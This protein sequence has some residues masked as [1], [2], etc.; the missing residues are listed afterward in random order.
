MSIKTARSGTTGYLTTTA[1]APKT[2]PNGDWTVGVAVLFDGPMSGYGAQA[3]YLFSTG[4]Y[5]AAGSFN[6]VFEPADSGS[7][8]SLFHLFLDNVGAAV[9]TS[10]IV[11]VAGKAYYFVFQR[12]GTTVSV[13]QCPILTTAPTDGSSVVASTSNNG[14]L[15]NSLSGPLN[16]VIGAR[17]DLADRYFGQ[18]YAR[19]FRLD[20]VTL[21][22]LE[23]AKLAYGMEITELGKTPSLYIR[24]NDAT[25]FTDQSTNAY[26][27]TKSGT[28]AN[29]SSM[30]FGYVSGATPAAPVITGSPSINNGA[31][32]GSASTY[33]PASV[34]GN[35]TPTR[36]L[37]WK[38]DGVAVSGATGTTYAPVAGDSGKTLTITQTEANTQ[39]STS[40]TSAGVVVATATA[41][42]DVA[43]LTAERIYQRVGTTSTVAMSGSYTSTTPTSIEYQLYAEDGVTILVPWTTIS[44][45]TIASGTWSGSPAV[46]QGGM[47][48]L[49][50]RSKNGADVLATSSIKT[51]LF[52]VGDLIA[53]IGSSSPAKWFSSDSGSGF[54]AAANVRRHISGSWSTMGTAG[55]AI[56]MAN[57]FA[58]NAG[59]PVGLLGYGVP[60][61][62]LAPGNSSYVDWLTQ[63]SAPWSN[64]AS[65][66]TAV[67]GKLKAC[68]ISVG[69]NDAAVSIVGSRASHL[70]NLRTFAGNI[71]TLCAQSSLPLLLSGFNRRNPV[72]TAQADFVRMAENDF[73]DDLNCYHN[74]A[75]DYELNSDL[76]HLSAT[77]FTQ[78]G[79]RMR[80]VLGE[81]LYSSTYHRGPKIVGMVYSG[82]TITVSLQHRNGTDFT[83]ST[84]INGFTIT[85][86]DSSG[87]APT[88]NSVARLSSTQILITCNRSLV[89]P[90][91][92]YLSGGAPV[93]A[94]TSAPTN[95]AFDNGTVALPV[96][97]ETDM[98]V[99]ASDSAAPTMVG[100]IV[101]S[102]V[103]TT[104]FTLTWQAATDAVGVTGYKVSVD[105]GSTY[106]DV[107]NVLTYTANGLAQNTLYNTR[108]YAYD[109]A[110]NTATPLS[111]A[112]TTATA[113]D[114]TAPVMVA[115]LASSNI[116]TSAFTLSWSAA[117]DNVAVTGY[118][119][120]ID[121]GATYVSAGNVLTVTKTG[122]S[123]ATLYNTKVRAFDAAGNRATPLSL[124]VTTATAADSAAPTMNGSITVSAQST[125]GFTLSWPA[126]SDNA[127]VTGYKV[128]TDNGVSYVDVGNVLTSTRSGL[129]A[130]TTYNVRVYAYDAAGNTA[131]PLTATAT[132][133][134]AADATAPVMTGT[135]S[136][137]AINSGGFTFSYAAA[138]DNVAITGYEVSVDT[139]VA[140]Y[141]NVGNVLSV[142]KVN[143]ASSTLYNIRVRAFDAAGN[144]S[145]V[146]TTTATTL[147]AQSLAS[148]LTLTFKNRAGVVQ[149]SLTG[150][151]WA[152][153]DAST[154][155]GLG[156]PSAKGTGATTNSSGILVLNVTG[157]QL[158]PGA[159][160][161]LV[162]SN[163]DGTAT[164]G[165]L[166]SFA[167]PCVVA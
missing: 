11:P 138:T 71:R 144:R 88:I 33:V 164:Q 130:G 160:G 75:L 16:L 165:N 127:G 48:K 73:G 27:I 90:V 150:M 21:T 113:T 74:Q 83:P 67:G 53:C 101:S 78:C 6:I 5:T 80:Y 42:I 56:P 64:F 161:W 122:L 123:S 117:T 89:T 119:V 3:Q 20:G 68:I 30:G 66:V 155:D 156:A 118:E 134:S 31:S 17:A 154:P 69:S 121:N 8:P 50:V 23:V 163:S 124:A 2:F 61:T 91:V 146:L 145:N 139:G 85:D 40:A 59:V 112:V 147:A 103:T 87:V 65:A 15:T 153:F 131:T 41:T 95:E 37:Q 151:K 77:G 133:T 58:I 13:R 102:S 19:L 84:A 129:S 60:G 93:S 38:L 159:T 96:T 120:S 26:A 135:I 45:A 111:L 140:S 141:A 14:T 149:A 107:G 24:A 62:A 36:T 86:S 43:Q 97:V 29:G 116:T 28:L 99:A 1:A 92:K 136:V 167:G 104:G 32:V 126:A 25:D 108:V 106:V 100:N 142:A 157:T 49:C 81:A 143:L 72:P 51:N 55:C 109:A 18:T 115:S 22:D 82:S 94:S 34:T 158:V 54:T 35:P 114:A 7:A 137:T 152:F 110:G 44:S 105:G 128:S 125:S 76:I 47:Y 63:S 148:S 9:A 4:G 166:I 57:G 132:T 79:N 162:F 46:P 98:L 39:G 52:G 70:A 12:S 10:P